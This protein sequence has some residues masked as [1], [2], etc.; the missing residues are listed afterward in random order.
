MEGRELPTFVMFEIGKD[1]WQG[2][3]AFTPDNLR[4]LNCQ[5]RDT[6]ASPRRQ[7]KK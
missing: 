3:T 5:R 7:A 1:G 2:M 6:L 4:Y